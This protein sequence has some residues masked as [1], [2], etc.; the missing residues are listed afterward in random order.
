MPLYDVFHR[1]QYFSVVQIDPSM[2]Y[3]YVSLEILFCL[4]PLSERIVIIEVGSHGIF[5]ESLKQISKRDEIWISWIFKLSLSWY[6]HKNCFNM[7]WTLSLL[8]FII[9]KRLA[10]Y[11]LSEFI[12]INLCV[13]RQDSQLHFL[14]RL[15]LWV[16]LR[17]VKSFLVDI[18]QTK[19][20]IPPH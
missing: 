8:S 3:I 1:E 20:A 9:H 6:N 18:L 13:S 5:S 2:S 11:F 10:F 12:K 17:N 15:S 4:L 16:S 7:K 19:V 14:C